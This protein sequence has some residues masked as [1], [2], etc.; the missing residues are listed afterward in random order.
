MTSPAAAASPQ[1]AIRARQ[2]SQTAGYFAAFVAVGLSTASLGP[3][4]TGLAANTGST[5]GQVSI[6]FTLRSF[7]YLLGSLLGGRLYDR[8]RGHPVISVAL[9]TMTAMLL[10]A[11]SV[12]NLWLLA[13]LMLVLSIAEGSIDV[14]GNTLLVWV[15]GHKVGPFMN[16][17]HFFFGLGAFIAPLIVAQAIALSGGF[18]ASYWLIALLV[19]PL[20]FVVL[21]LPSPPHPVHA[22]HGDDARPPADMRLVAMMA[23]FFFLYVGM[24]LVYGGWIAS[25]A[26]SVGYGD[27]AAAAVLTSA[28]WGSFTVGRL[29]AIPIGARVRPKIIM[30]AD[31]L[32]VMLFSIFILV[33]GNSAAVLWIGTLGIGFSMA[34]MFATMISFAE[35]RMRITGKVTSFFLAGSSIGGM[36]LPFLVGQLFGV[37]GPNA[38]V[39]AVLLTA[40]MSAIMFALINAFANRR[41]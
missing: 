8:V 29:I 2:L 18:A 25:Y 19:L 38:M 22:E 6:L 10:L 26:V 13:A 24:E 23:V 12:A 5:L 27:A 9:V 39:W 1:H 15:H 21:R 20:A 33:G 7:G 36:T 28:F 14:G 41:A 32:G 17:L 35:T 30:Y 3:T 16:A 11:P 31:L 40:I 4:L 37:V 34:S